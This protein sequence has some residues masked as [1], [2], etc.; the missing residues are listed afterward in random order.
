VIVVGSGDKRSTPDL[1]LLMVCGTVCLV[2]LG[3]LAW[4]TLVELVNPETDTGGAVTVVNNVV[5]TLVG[6]LA[7]YL[8]GRTRR[9]GNGS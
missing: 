3:S 1:M 2:V 9:N 8:A 7:G 6:L 5:S 4:V